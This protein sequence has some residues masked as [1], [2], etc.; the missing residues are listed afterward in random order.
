MKKTY[1]EIVSTVREAARDAIRLEAT[2]N[3]RTK[4]LTLAKHTD[5]LKGNIL[6]IDKRIARLNFA[7]SEI[8]DNDP[9]KEELMKEH[10]EGLENYNKEK[11]GIAKEQAEIDKMVEELNLKIQDI[12]SGKVLVSTERLED[13]TKVYLAKASETLMLESLA[14][15]DKE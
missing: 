13:L 4:L 2:N 10:N 8:K 5:C 1:N 3:V 15:A 11:E 14:G 9:D 6:N 12:Q 7:I